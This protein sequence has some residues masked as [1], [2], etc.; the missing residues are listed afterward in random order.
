[1]AQR[2]NWVRANFININVMVRLR[3]QCSQKDPQEW[4]DTIPGSG[5]NFNVRY[6]VLL[7]LCF[8]FYCPKH[9]ICQEI[10]QYLQHCLFI[11]YT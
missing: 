1:M 8:Y 10:F 9:I 7:L 4:P 5:K 2:R 3:Y 11:Q 6:R